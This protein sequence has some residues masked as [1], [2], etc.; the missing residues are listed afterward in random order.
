MHWV[1]LIKMKLLFVILIIIDFDA[2]LIV[3]CYCYHNVEQ[4]PWSICDSSIQQMLLILCLTFS[5]EIFA[6]ACF[7]R[8]IS[9]HVKRRPSEPTKKKTPTKFHFGKMSTLRICLCSFYLPM[10]THIRSS[11]IVL[12]IIL[13]ITIMHSNAWYMC[14][15]PGPVVGFVVPWGEEIFLCG[16]EPIFHVFRTSRLIAF[17]QWTMMLPSQHPSMMVLPFRLVPWSNASFASRI[18]NGTAWY[19]ILV[20]IY[21]CSHS[22]FLFRSLFSDVIIILTN[23]NTNESCPNG[24][25]WNS[26][27]ARW[28][29]HFHRSQSPFLAAC[30]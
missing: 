30:S 6:N 8:N 27:S 24:R 10:F 1:R 20:R 7:A 21:I 23:N 5:M 18:R 11:F 25:K 13:I 15:V 9:D 12:A 14:T 29:F 17:F 16:L 2:I 28:E 22:I 19:N 3:H 4:Q 26:H